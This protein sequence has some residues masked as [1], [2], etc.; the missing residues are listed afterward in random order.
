MKTGLV[1]ISSC[2]CVIIASLVGSVV[3][4]GVL[5]GVEIGVVVLLDEGIGISDTGPTSIS[6]GRARY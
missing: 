1:S 4:E 5:F 3:I 6:S 2:S